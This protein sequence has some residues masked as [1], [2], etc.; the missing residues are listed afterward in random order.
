[1]VDA[2]AKRTWVYVQRPSSYEIA[3]CKCG[4]A[5]P[6]WSEFKGM[7]WCPTCLIDFVPEHNGVFDG[8]IPVAAAAL[9]GMSFDRFNLE[10]QEVERDEHGVTGLSRPNREVA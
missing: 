6:D 5:D 2:P 8:P 3:G 1:M 9:L 4:N 7:L 10:T